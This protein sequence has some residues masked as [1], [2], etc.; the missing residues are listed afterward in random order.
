MPEFAVEL[1]LRGVIS[2]MFIRRGHDHAET[3]LIIVLILALIGAC[4]LGLQPRLGLWA[5]RRL[6]LILIIVVV[7]ALIGRI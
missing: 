6:G 7:L 5:R 2:H 3:I 4:R 1:W